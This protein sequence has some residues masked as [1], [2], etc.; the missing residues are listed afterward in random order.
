MILLMGVLIG[1]YFVLFEIGL[2]A[3]FCFVCLIWM[4]LLC[5]CCVFSLRLLLRWLLINSVVICCV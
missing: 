3:E 5:F 1:G 2:G 4:I